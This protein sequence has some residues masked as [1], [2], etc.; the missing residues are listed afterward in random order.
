MGIDWSPEC[1]RPYQRGEVGALVGAVEVAVARPLGL[2]PEPPVDVSALY[3]VHVVLVVAAG[4]HQHAEEVQVVAQVLH[5]SRPLAA[6]KHG[7]VAEQG[8][9][10]SRRE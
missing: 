1:R 8:L 3:E 4:P 7:T 10:K 9:C 2:L 5:Q 6:G